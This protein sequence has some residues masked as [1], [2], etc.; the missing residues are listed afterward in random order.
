MN[1][2]DFKAAENLTVR[3]TFFPT[4][5]HVCLHVFWGDDPS[6]DLGSGVYIWDGAEWVTKAGKTASPE[7]VME[8]MSKKLTWNDLSEDTVRD[9]RDSGVL[10]AVME[11]IG[12]HHLM[13]YIMG[14]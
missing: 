7:Q 8:T 2:L 12:T 6:D 13:M 4:S 11:D 1:T 10:K 14:T 5:G 9:F 3:L